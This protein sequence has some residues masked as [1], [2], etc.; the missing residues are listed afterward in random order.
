MHVIFL[1]L[2]LLSASGQSGAKTLRLT[3]L[4]VLETAALLHAVEQH[5]AKQ[6]A[7]STTFIPWTNPDQLKALL[8]SG[9]ID[10]AI[11]PSNIA[12]T[13]YNKKLPYKLLLVTEA[14]GLLT[15]VSRD[16]TAQDITSLKGSTIAVP[17]RHSMPDLI[18]TRT[19]Q[20]VGIDPSEDINIRYTGTPVAAAQLLLLGK[21]D[22][23]FLAEPFTTIALMRSKTSSDT[24]ATKLFHSIAVDRAWS[25]RVTPGQG[26]MVGAVMVSADLAQDTQRVSRL[27]RAFFSSFRA[28]KEA[29]ETGA[30][31]LAAKFPKLNPRIVAMSLQRI[32]SKA[33][34]AAAKKKEFMG[35]L[36]V[37]RAVYPQA[38]G[39]QLPNSDL[40]VK[41][42]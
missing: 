19:L 25:Q 18:L 20:A 36:E 16:R 30:K 38:I 8:V 15:V 27:A 22:H 32:Q 13:L 37:L 4:P 23:A 24:S 17:F 12:V 31:V 40:F 1:A 14:S 28:I 26:P 42:E 29:P 39:G 10:V 33:W 6:F 7:L 3:G 35:F 34:P 2:G 21:V 9:K 11:I 41:I 5:T